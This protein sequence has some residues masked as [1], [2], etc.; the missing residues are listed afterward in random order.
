MPIVN[1]P[2]STYC[3]ES[4]WVAQLIESFWGESAGF[5][6]STKKVSGFYIDNEGT[7]FSSL[8]LL[9]VPGAIDAILM[10]ADEGFDGW[11]KFYLRSDEPL[12]SDFDCSI[13]SWVSDF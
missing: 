12:S 8:N 11:L 1:Y 7:N 6:S 9:W 3:W 13:I 10:L 5:Y 4:Y 2:T